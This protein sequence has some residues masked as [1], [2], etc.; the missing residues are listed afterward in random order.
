MLQSIRGA[1]LA[2]V[3]AALVAVA[4]A[5][6]AIATPASAQSYDE[7]S[8]Y[9]RDYDRGAYDRY[10]YDQSDGRHQGSD[11][12]RFDDQDDA[13]D[14]SFFYSELAGDGRWISHHDYGNVWSPNGV[15]DD[16]RPYTRGSWAYTNEHGWYWV[17]EEPF[18]WATYHYGRWF[19]DERYGWLWVPGTTWGPAWVAWRSSDDYVGWAPLPPEAY[20]DSRS[21]LRHDVTLYESPRFAFYWSFIEPR[22]ITSPGL[23]R[24]CAPRHRARTIIYRTRPQTNYSFINARIVN[25]GL[26][27]G[28]VERRIGAPLTRLRVYSTDSRRARGFD[29]RAGNVIRVWRPDIRRR[30][31]WVKQKSALKLPRG[32]W[33]DVDRP[34]AARPAR[35]TPGRDTSTWGNVR[36]NYGAG[37]DVP[38]TGS[39]SAPVT[40]QWAP[41]KRQPWFTIDK[42]RDETMRNRERNRLDK[43]FNANQNWNQKRFD[44]PPY[45]ANPGKPLP[46]DPYTGTEPPPQVADPRTVENAKAKKKAAKRPPENEVYDTTTPPAGA[47]GRPAPLNQNPGKGTGA[48]DNIR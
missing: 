37:A 47:T 1:W 6:F 30:D 44:R 19:H 27:I 35:A 22:Y 11:D 33:H 26:S 8:E 28:F 9:D 39:Q 25:G 2:Q 7:D 12:S 46:R 20:W 18:G 40:R 15:D 16:W 29:R 42:Y 41:A 43:R 17:S 36:Q 23:Y 4:P 24:Y 3:L 48:F 38:Q 10:D 45:P 14:V 32:S 5:P 34:A 31:T 21:G 13:P